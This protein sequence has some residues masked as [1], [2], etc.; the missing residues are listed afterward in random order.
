MIGRFGFRNNLLF[1]TWLALF[2]CYFIG[3]V[4]Q[5]AI[6][7]HLS[8]WGLLGKLINRENSI[9][10][11]INS[12]QLQVLGE[13]LGG[14]IG[15]NPRRSKIAWARANHKRF[16]LFSTSDESENHKSRFSLAEKQTFS[17]L[18]HHWI[19][20]PRL[21]GSQTMRKFTGEHLFSEHSLENLEMIFALK[22]R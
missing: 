21:L 8:N 4:Q 5:T 2:D 11:G 10:N 3:G 7:L 13:F 19:L 16:G 15:G 6:P 22:L 17:F 9:G 20:P 18:N 12:L 14:F 1:H